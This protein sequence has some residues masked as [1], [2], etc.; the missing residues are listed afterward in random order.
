MSINKAK[1]FFI[2]LIL[3]SLVFC[4]STNDSVK[5]DS[6]A[7][8]Y[9]NYPNLL[10]D[11][12]DRIANR[13][14]PPI[15]KDW[16]NYPDIPGLDKYQQIA[17]LTVSWDSVE[18]KGESDKF[19]VY[20]TALSL[21]WDRPIVS[22]DLYAYPKKIESKQ[23]VMDNLLDVLDM[24]DDVL[25]SLLNQKKESVLVMKSISAQDTNSIKKLN[26]KGIEVKT[27]NQ[28]P[29]LTLKLT[30]LEE[31]K[32]RYD[33]IHS[34][35]P[36]TML[37]VE[38]RWDALKD[39][40]MPANHKWWRVSKKTGKRIEY[41]QGTPVRYETDI[42]NPEYLSWLGERCRAILAT[43]VI[44]F[45]FFD[46]MQYSIEHGE[47]PLPML[48][49]VREKVGPK[50]IIIGNTHFSK[51]PKLC[52]YIDAWGEADVPNLDS[53]I[54]CEKNGRKAPKFNCW[55]FVGKE[56]DDQ[57]MRYFTTLG[58][59]NTNSSIR[60][61]NHTGGTKPSPWYFFWNTEIGKALNEPYPK[62]VNGCYTREYENGT[63]VCNDSGETKK[64]TFNEIRERAS[65]G[66]R[67]KEFDVANKDGEMFLIAK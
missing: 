20:G 59:T 51:Y 37:G 64:F 45:I 41:S 42:Y 15:Y 22:N 36:N 21:E 47:D 61:I 34:Y 65:T 26:L 44:D 54:W 49:A 67:K 31:A 4:K 2:L 27:E 35:N 30:N 40:E 9:L 19:G 29:F 52:D 8:S 33:L 12:S 28:Y 1:Y 57:K 56:T 53:M 6:K 62:M 58:M 66:E 25:D 55:E 11:F 13:T 50:A 17:K 24:S 23:D 46:H 38:I 14:K 63:T 60:F 3:L 16:N 18:P 5:T 48:K 43:G 39:F 7:D 10:R 32:R